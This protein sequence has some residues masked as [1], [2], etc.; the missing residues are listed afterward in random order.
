[1]IYIGI[2]IIGFIA[3]DIFDLVSLKRLPFGL[4]PLLWSA[5]C[6]L[7]LYSVTMLCL[8][9]N[10][11]PISGWL[12]WAGWGLLFI[13][14][15]M[16]IL[17]LFINLPFHKTY[18]KA[19]VGDKLIRTGL[20]ALVRHPGVYWIASFMFSLVLVSKSNL[21]LIGA[22]V[23]TVLNTVFV[24]IE[25]KYFFVKMFDDYHEYQKETPMLIPN[26]RS[27]R[28]FMNSVRKSQ[29][30]SAPKQPKNKS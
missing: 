11:L 30:P 17:V 24:I 9:S 21:M 19:G 4:K 27:I 20:Y 13:S 28:A 25:D 3:M 2:G 16:L 6:I 1:M 14:L 5:S 26:R 18:V 23:F 8:E 29:R 22:I 12:T 7:L 15:L 10:D